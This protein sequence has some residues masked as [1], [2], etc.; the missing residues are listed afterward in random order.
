MPKRTEDLYSKNCKTLM[1]KSKTTQTDGKIY[2][3]LGLEESVLSKWL[4]YPREFYRFSAIP[5][6]LPIP[7]KFFTEF[8]TEYFKICMEIQETL[9]SQSSIEIE[10]QKWRN[11][12]SWLEMI[13]Q[14]YSQNSVVLAQNRNI[15]QWIRI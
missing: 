5:I 4:Y 9:N 1:K 3:A 14:S 12:A 13:L 2:H 7:I 10:N 6:K 11:Q 15:D 8:R